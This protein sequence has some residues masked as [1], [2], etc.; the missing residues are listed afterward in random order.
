MAK[1]LR[2]KGEEASTGTEQRKGEEA[3]EETIA[4][5]KAPPVSEEGNSR[6]RK[7]STGRDDDR[8]EGRRRPAV[9]LRAL[10]VLG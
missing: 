1:G 4:G 3:R 6:R 7:S 8:V 2:L 5:H 10:L 9:V